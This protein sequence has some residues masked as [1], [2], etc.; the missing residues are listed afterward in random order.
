MEP[1]MPRPPALFLTQGSSTHIDSPTLE[2]PLMVG[3]LQ[4]PS[5]RLRNRTSRGNCKEGDST[6]IYNTTDGRNR[7]VL[8][9]DLEGVRSGDDDAFRRIMD[10]YSPLVFGVALEITQ[11]EADAEDV[12]QEVFIRLPAALETFRLGDFPAWLKKV[13][14]RQALMYVRTEARHR[15]NTKSFMRGDRVEATIL[16]RIVVDKAVA[17]LDLDLRAVYVLK[18]MEGFS[19]A[20]IAETIGISVNLSQVR[21]FRARAALRAI[22]E[23]S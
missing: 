20:E 13:T 23:P 9:T 3:K 14:T 16:S 18:E 2:M 10:A 5:E 19:H 8:S 17:Q 15:R 22:I 7:G 11:S 6:S 1:P 12:L 21:L 4:L